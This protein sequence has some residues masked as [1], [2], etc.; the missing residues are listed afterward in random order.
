MKNPTALFFALLLFPLLLSA[1]ANPVYASNR[2]D[3]ALVHACQVK[4]QTAESSD[5]ERAHGYLVAMEILYRKINAVEETK[6]DHEKR[7]IELKQEMAFLHA[8]IL[9]TQRTEREEAA[10]LFPGFPTLENFFSLHSLEKSW[11]DRYPQERAQRLSIRIA[12]AKKE[13][14]DLSARAQ[15]IS[16]EFQFLNDQYQSAREQKDVHFAR[17]NV[18][19]FMFNQGCYTQ[20]CATIN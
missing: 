11:R 10:N 16:G 1:Q 2:C 20:F 15:K 14:S 8:E 4:S 12:E 3:P 5:R 7:L 19:I 9:F 18:H 13:E 6:L 17:V